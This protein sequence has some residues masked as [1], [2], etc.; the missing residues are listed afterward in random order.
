ME[1]VITY[2]DG[3]NLYYGLK[4]A[5]WRRYYW[6]D[7]VALA[8]QFLSK[9][10]RLDQVKYFTAEIA[11]NNDKVT[12]QRTFLSALSNHCK[13]GLKIIKGKYFKKSVTCY[14]HQF[15]SGRPNFS[16]CL[17]YHGFLC[18]G[19]LKVPEEKMTDVNIATAMLVDAFTDKFDTA[20][21]LTG[22]TDL[23]P[24]IKAIM[25]MDSPKKIILLFPPKRISE[26]LK[27]LIGLQRCR[28][29]K[30]KHLLQSLLPLDVTTADGSILTKPPRWS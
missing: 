1:R 2:V 26:D 28:Y 30:E 22:D 17:N 25:N 10:Q 21:L 19:I 29:V 4:A 12:R 15:A 16:P 27:K 5:N 7:L 8:R 20:F 3:F 11:G 9:N 14:T 23:I 24:P 18:N 13:E 6:L